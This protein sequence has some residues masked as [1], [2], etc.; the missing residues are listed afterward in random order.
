MLHVVKLI[1]L[2]MICKC[3]RIEVIEVRKYGHMIWEKTS[4]VGPNK[5][6]RTIRLLVWM[7]LSAA[8]IMMLTGGVCGD[9]LVKF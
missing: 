9:P 1:D 8:C 5:Q 7:K 2:L 4:L 6:R 3:V